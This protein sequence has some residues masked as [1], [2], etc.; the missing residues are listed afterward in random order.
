MDK[1]LPSPSGSQQ[2]GT[3]T[4]SLSGTGKPSCYFQSIK[5]GQVVQVPWEVQYW[6]TE[7][8]DLLSPLRKAEKIDALTTLFLGT[9]RSVSD[10]V[11]GIGAQTRVYPKISCQ[12]LCLGFIFSSCTTIFQIVFDFLKKG[13]VHTL[14]SNKC[15][16]VWER[17]IQSFLNFHL[18]YLSP[19]Y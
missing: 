10:S 4:D 6:K 2:L 3:F 15:V 7:T 8:S 13:D 12:L 16:Y 5:H 17:T 9:W 19:A 11:P 18:V 14:S 1:L